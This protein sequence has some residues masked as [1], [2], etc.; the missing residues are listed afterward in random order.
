MLFFLDYPKYEAD[1]YAHVI[2]SNIPDIPLYL[3]VHNFRELSNLELMS[4]R[5]SARDQLVEATNYIERDRKTE[6]LVKMMRYKKKKILKV[7]NDQK[8]D[9]LSCE[10][11]MMIFEMLENS[12]ILN[13]KVKCVLHEINLIYCFFGQ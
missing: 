6:F 2:L 4:I 5:S 3:L 1:I 7:S 10:N 12:V 9:V 13:A 8:F 11:A